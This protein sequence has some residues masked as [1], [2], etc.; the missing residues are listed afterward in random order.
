MKRA[1]RKRPDPDRLVALLAGLVWFL[2]V[3]GQT[4]FLAHLAGQPDGLAPL[5]AQLAPSPTR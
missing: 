4:M 3:F 1:P 2:V 5:T